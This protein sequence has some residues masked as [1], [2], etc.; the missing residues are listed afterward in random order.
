M[1]NG[2]LMGAK[3]VIAFKNTVYPHDFEMVLN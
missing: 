3:S 1:V 2:L